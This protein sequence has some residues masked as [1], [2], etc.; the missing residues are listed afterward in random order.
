VK[1]RQDTE[2]GRKRRC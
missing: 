2:Q 1:V